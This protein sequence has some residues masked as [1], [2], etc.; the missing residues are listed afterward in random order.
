M[1]VEAPP[2]AEESMQ[3]EQT[4]A[5]VSAEQE[6]QQQQRKK[7]QVQKILANVRQ[8][9]GKINVAPEFSEEDLVP[10]EMPD[11]DMSDFSGS[12]AE[13]EDAEDER[14]EEDDS[15]VDNDAE[16]STGDAEMSVP[17]NSQTETNM[18]KDAKSS[19]QV[20]QE[21]DAKI[22]K[23]KHFLDR[24]KSKRFSAIRSVLCSRSHFTHFI[25]SA[26]SFC[27]FILRYLSLRG[28]AVIIFTPIMRIFP[29]MHF[30]L[31]FNLQFLLS[32]RPHLREQIQMTAVKLLPVQLN[33][34]SLQQISTEENNFLSL[35]TGS[36]FFSLDR[37]PK[38]LSDK[39]FTDVK[40]KQAAAKQAQKKA[41]Q[42]TGMSPCGVAYGIGL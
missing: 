13:E 6:E 20:L 25:L 19:K 35:V 42:T 14:L 3:E 22:A 28:W 16:K 27:V 26:F 37:I 9:F 12:E 10:V 18:E 33:Y 29:I 23:Y 39:V 40:T 41:S 1:P 32:W 5:S 2:D 38:A 36:L 30:F 7:E 4:D 15:N 24:A 21:L 11:L 8:N 17:T 34:C 31:F